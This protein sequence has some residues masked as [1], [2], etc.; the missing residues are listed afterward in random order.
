MN[1]DL[2]KLQHALLK[3]KTVSAVELAKITKCSI[4]TV[5]R[6]IL[7]LQDAGAIIAVSREARKKTGP[8]PKKFTLVA[9]ASLT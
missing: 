4:P 5:Y 2:E 8:T 9:V 3:H 1:S 7:A 6:R